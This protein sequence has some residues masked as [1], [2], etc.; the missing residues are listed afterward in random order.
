MQSDQA[1]YL[2][3]DPDPLA[4]LSHLEAAI[5]H[6]A[7]EVFDRETD[8]VSASDRMAATGAV[9]TTAAEHP[10]AA[11]QCAPQL[12]T[13]LTHVTTATETEASLTQGERQRLVR[14]LCGAL[15]DIATETPSAVYDHLTDLQTLLAADALEARAVAAEVLAQAADEYPAQFQHPDAV[16]SATLGDSL[17]SIQRHG[18][19]IA[20]TLCAEWPA[21]VSAN[22]PTLIDLLDAADDDLRQKAANAIHEIS[23]VTPSR[24]AEDTD[25]LGAHLRDSDGH[26]RSLIILV[27]LELAEVDHE[28]IWNYADDIRWNLTQSHESARERAGVLLARLSI[29]STEKLPTLVDILE[30]ALKVETTESL[31]IPVQQLAN[32]HPA[33]ATELYDL[34]LQEATGEDWELDTREDFIIAAYW[35][36]EATDAVPAEE[37]LERLKPVLSSEHAALRAAVALLYLE[38]H[39]IAPTK[40][41]NTLRAPGEAASEDLTELAWIDTDAFDEQ[42][43]APV[44]KQIQSQA[45]SK[46]GEVDTTPPDTADLIEP[47]YTWARKENPSVVLQRAVDAMQRED[48]TVLAEIDEVVSYLSR[49]SRVTQ[50]VAIRVFYLASLKHPQQAARHLDEVLDLTTSP[51]TQIRRSALWIVL[52]LVDNNPKPVV[53]NPEPFLDGLTHEDRLTRQAAAWTLVEISSRETSGLAAVVDQLIAAIETEHVLSS[54][55][56]EVVLADIVATN[57]ESLQPHTG[58]L[59]E[60]LQLG[61]RADPDEFKTVD[62]LVDLETTEAEDEIS[63]SLFPMK[64]FLNDQNRID[65]R[66]LMSALLSLF[67]FDSSLSVKHSDGIRDLLGGAA[68]DTKQGLWLLGLTARAGEPGVAEFAEDIST[69]LLTEKAL[70]PQ[71]T[72]ELADCLVSVTD[73]IPAAFVPWVDELISRLLEIEE[74]AATD[75]DHHGLVTALL[76]LISACLTEMDPERYPTPDRFLAF[77]KYDD[78]AGKHATSI[79]GRLVDTYP[80]EGGEA[81]EAIVEWCAS[82]QDTAD[83]VGAV[84]FL[85]RTG[86]VS[87]LNETFETAHED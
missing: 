12:L 47:T 49:N 75:A 9:A 22:I 7:P 81:R 17:V 70:N 31:S 2:D 42:A 44:L 48:R 41:E 57:P 52:T 84:E 77:L 66:P 3:S 8:D 46:V 74:T 55:A 27:F 64:E 34:L 19:D 63:L 21:E 79:L 37:T 10:L 1:P 16:L 56:V 26:F 14:E 28:A 54:F 59:L 45:E 25:V 4:V 61:L 13:V 58:P 60:K 20:A 40:V 71:V 69:L 73:V 11:S 43:T 82:S 32:I 68:R 53:E 6:T 36:T 72:E 33:P 5:E 23:I 62:S 24:V 39:E 38:V 29:L 50:R 30:T 86:S 35:I 18:A 65:E 76:G 51:F 87:T 15:R 85:T 67:L 80:S 78:D 83:L